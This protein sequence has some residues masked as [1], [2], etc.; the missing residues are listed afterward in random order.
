MRTRYLVISIFLLCSHEANAKVSATD[1]A[2]SGGGGKAVVCRDSEKQIKSVELLDLWEARVIFGRN[3]P[4]SNENVDVQVARVF[5]QMK[6]A[7]RPN[8]SGSEYA[9]DSLRATASWFLEKNNPR[10]KWLKGMELVDVPDSY[11]VAKPRDCNIEQLVNFINSTR[12]LVDADLWSHMDKTNQAATIAHE[13]F[14]DL[15]RGFSK[16][17]NSVRARRVVGYTFAGGTFIPLKSVL[18]SEALE[19]F[20]S[21]GY[22]YDFTNVYIHLI[23]RYGTLSAVIHPIEINDLFAIGVQDLPMSLSVPESVKTLDDLLSW[24]KTPSPPGETSSQ[25]TSGNV[26][27]AYGDDTHLTFTRIVDGPNVHIEVTIES[28][29]GGMSTTPQ[30]LTCMKINTNY[31]KD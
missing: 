25:R 3:I 20:G 9:L 23:D 28:A 7:V 22:S 6:Y 18:P 15:L 26:D 27:P 16:E 19:C 5:E 8:H 14:Y 4:S 1:G 30:V 12:I 11:E 21:G 2:I 24:T 17:S 31:L 29:P 10:V 13:S